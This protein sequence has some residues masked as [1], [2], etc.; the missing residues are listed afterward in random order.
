MEL[1]LTLKAARV[2]SGVSREQAAKAC[3]KNVSTLSSYEN[4]HTV[5]DVETALIL[6][7]LYGYSISQL[8]FARRSD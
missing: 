4:G 1:K 8:T 5:P 6:A 3:G 2:N 7:G